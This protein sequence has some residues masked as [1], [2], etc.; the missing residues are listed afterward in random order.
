MPPPTVIVVH[1]R[2]N[3]KKCSVAPLEGREGF[4]FWR[5]PFSSREPLPGYVQLGMNGPFLSEADAESGLLVLDA[6]WRLAAWKTAYPRVSKNFDDPA[7]GL[8]TIEAIYIAYQILGRD[9]TGLLDHYHWKEQFQQANA[10]RI[11]VS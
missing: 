3:P 1:R 9:T 6:T 4:V 8:A 7:G 10:E 11:R 2:E 5:Y